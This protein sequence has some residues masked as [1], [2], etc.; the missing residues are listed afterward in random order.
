MGKYLLFFL[1][2]FSNVGW[3]ST[4]Y[5]INLTKDEVVIDSGS[6]IIRPIASVTKLMTALVILDS[7]FNLDEKVPYKG[8]FKKEMSRNELLSLML[9]KSDNKAA[10]ALA[11]SLPGG[12]NLFIAEMNIKAISIGM[13]N[14][15]YDDPSGLSAGNTSTA[16]DQALLLNH[17]YDYFKMRDIASTISYELP[18]Q[19]KYKRKVTERLVTITN[20]NHNLL[21]EYREIIISKTGTT[22]AAGKCLAMLVNHNG[23]RYAV[24]I[25]GEKNRKTIEEL[26][27]KIFKTFL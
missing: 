1:F 25:L 22:S 15:H 21:T 17:S 2:F 18:V 10:E 23:E 3:C 27:R 4:K 20:T 11:S 13:K 24:V 5:V 14:T 9:V 6:Q 19:S 26:S 12:R 7:E 16:K 8:L